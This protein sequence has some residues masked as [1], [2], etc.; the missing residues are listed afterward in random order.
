MK[1]TLAILLA[2]MLAISALPAFA[3][4]TVSARTPLD[5]ANRAMLSNIDLAM[6]RIDGMSVPYGESF[7]FNDTV[8]PRTKAYGYQTAPNARG[9]K[10][11]GGGVAQVATTLYLALLEI[12]SGVDFTALQTYGARFAGNYVS[13]GELAVMIDYSTD[14]DFAFA[15]YSDDMYIQMW[16][17]DSYLY[18]T[19][20]QSGA[21]AAVKSSFLDW[22]SPAQFHSGWHELIGSS[23]IE[24]V[25]DENLINNIILAANSINDTTL[26]AGALFSFNET[27]GPRAE[28]Y[29][30]LPAI[31]GRGIEVVGGGVAQA[32]SA[33]WLAIRNADEISVAAKS[34]YGDKYNQDYV[35]NSNDAILTDYAAGTDF[36]FRNISGQTLTIEMFVAENILYCNICRS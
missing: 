29:G 27:V 12:D 15:N 19:I 25:G 13:D 21:Q 11:T 30:Y 20:T 22:N 9:A 6:R 10:V 16:M 33:L 26:P 32:A 4:A 36:S 5:T 14:I 8:G 24:I 17:T 3:V 28:K 31:N 7:S 2:L 23:M 34:T 18:C 35:L 1:R